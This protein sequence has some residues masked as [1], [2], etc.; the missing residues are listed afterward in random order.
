MP[1]R[2]GRLTRVQDDLGLAVRA[3]QGDDDCGGWIKLWYVTTAAVVVL[4]G[5]NLVELLG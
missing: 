5:L 3:G 2:H 1:Q 4:L